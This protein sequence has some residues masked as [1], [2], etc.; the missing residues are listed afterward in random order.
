MVVTELGIVNDV[1][2][3]NPRNASFSMLF[4]PSGIIVFLQP[5]INAFVLVLIMALHPFA[6]LN[7]RFSSSTVIVS[8][9][10]HVAKAPSYMLY[11][12]FGIVT[13]VSPQHP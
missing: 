2:V 4:T 9:L 12:F 6:E 13:E 8:R 11:T 7:Q 10:R 3:G 5:W 1:I